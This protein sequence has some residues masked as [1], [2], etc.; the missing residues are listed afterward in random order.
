MSLID[1]IRHGPQRTAATATAATAATHAPPRGSTVAAVA[2][3]AVTD[4]PKPATADGQVA[5]ADLH[6]DNRTVEAVDLP[7]PEVTPGVAGV[8]TVAASISP[9]AGQGSYGPANTMTADATAT[10]ATVATSPPDGVADVAAVAVAQSVTGETPTPLFGAGS[11]TW[12]AD[13][14]IRLWLSRIG[15]TDADAVDTVVE[16]CR[17]EVDVRAYFLRRANEILV[18]GVDDRRYCAECANRTPV[19]FCLAARRGEIDAAQSYRPPDHLPRRCEG[20]LP[21]R[22]DADQRS[23]RE[24]WPPIAT[25][26]DDNA[27]A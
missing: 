24:R 22:N 2:G 19:G 27:D 6:C 13:Q 8:A 23:G 1:L 10:P 17:S 9:Q 12:R 21:N 11:L 25:A 5:P 15:E 16:Q 7:A 20:Y 26:G 14:H 4:L 18:D 3:V